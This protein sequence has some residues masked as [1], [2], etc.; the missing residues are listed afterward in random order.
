MK[1][2]AGAADSASRVESGEPPRGVPFAPAPCREASAIT[3]QRHEVRKYGCT[4]T[5]R[6]DLNGPNRP[7]DKHPAVV[8]AD[9]SRRLT[10]REASMMPACLAVTRTTV[11]RTS[12][13]SERWKPSSMT[14]QQ[15]PFGRLPLSESSSRIN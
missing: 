3:L 12:P 1:E 10:G 13:S 15:A 2:D 11:H 14:S 6:E 9:A 5:R 4:R 8:A 7:P